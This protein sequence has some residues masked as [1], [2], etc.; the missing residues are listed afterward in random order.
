MVSSRSMRGIARKT[1]SHWSGRQGLLICMPMWNTTSSPSYRCVIRPAI[2]LLMA[3][4]PWIVSLSIMDSGT[5]QVKEVQM[6]ISE[7]AGATGVTVPTIKYYLRE[8]L[9]SEGARTSATQAEYGEDHVRRLRVVRAL[10]ESGVTV[11]ETRKV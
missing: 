7:L 9:L 4:P 6:R 5:I 11:A 3:C 10:I 2:T 8:G 1:G